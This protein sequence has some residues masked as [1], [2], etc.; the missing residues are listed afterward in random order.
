M[1]VSGVVQAD[2]KMESQSIIIPK[3]AVL[4]TGKRS[5][6]YVKENGSFKL[7]EVTLGAALGDSYKINEGIEVGERS[8]R[9]APYFGRSRSAIGQNQHDE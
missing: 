5:V 4:W 1:F 7:R 6:V 2:R 8:F 9:M 3:S